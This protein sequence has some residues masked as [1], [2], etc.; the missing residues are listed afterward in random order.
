MRKDFIY[1]AS[2][3]PRRRALLEQLGVPFEVRPAEISEIRRPDEDPGA[4]VT[5]LAR[6]KADRIWEEFADRDARPVLAADT[7]VV[8]DGQVLGKPRDDEHALQ[9]LA[10][11]SGKKHRVLTAVAVRNGA[12]CTSAL[13]SSEVTFRAMTDSERRAYVATGEPA[14]KAGSYAIQGK[15]A[16]FIEHISG[17]YSGVMGL[18]LSLTAALLAELRLPEWLYF[19]EHAS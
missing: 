7:T 19:S 12:R 4:Y 16:V 18:P 15:G 2:A 6:E 17:S 14:G 3:S 5:R 8:V 9:M 13:S 11:L 1:L 10:D